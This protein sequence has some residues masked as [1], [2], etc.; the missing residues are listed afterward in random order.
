MLVS[1]RK[2][3]LLFT[4]DSQE[5]V[6]FRGNWETLPCFGRFGDAVARAI[7]K[8]NHWRW[9]CIAKGRLSSL[10]VGKLRFPNSSGIR[11]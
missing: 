1:A 3:Q 9:V 7:T 11:K 5:R 10:E 2:R 4:S 6:R 8:D